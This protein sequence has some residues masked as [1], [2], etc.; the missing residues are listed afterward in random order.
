MAYRESLVQT[1]FRL[2]KDL[3]HKLE[4]EAER[5]DR[6]VNDEVAR[7][8]EAS[9]GYEEDIQK[10]SKE[11]E[12]LIRECDQMAAERHMIVTAMARDGRTHP[13]PVETLAALEALDNSVERRLQA[14]TFTDD[15][16]WGDRDKHPAKS[17]SKRP[18]AAA[19]GSPPAR[20]SVKS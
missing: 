6:A 5:H 10:L 17:A 13:H 12:R 16:M 9:F 3:L 8:L 2:R 20:K 4:R 14:E 7:R 11:C 19:V 15:Y 18:P 1:R